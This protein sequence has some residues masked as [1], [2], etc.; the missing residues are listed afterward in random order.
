MRATQAEHRASLARDDAQA[1]ERIAVE[2]RVEAETKRGEAEAA[3]RS[4]RRTL[5]VSDIRLAQAAWGSGNLDELRRLLERQRPRPGEDD[6]RGF[7][8]HYLRRLASSVRVVGLP[9]QFQSAAIS[10][11]GARLVATRPVA[12]DGGREIELCLLDGSTG[13]EV[14]RVF[15]YPGNDSLGD[16]PSARFSPDGRRFVYYKGYIEATGRAVGLEGQGLG[17]GDRP[18]GL[19]NVRPLGDRRRRGV[20]RQRVPPGAGDRRP[21]PEGQRADR[22]RGRRRQDAPDDP[23]GGTP[24]HRVVDRL[25]PRRPSDRRPRPVGR[26]RLARD[27]RAAHLGR[28]RRRGDPPGRDRAGVEVPGLQPRRPSDR[29]LARARG[30]APGP[31]RRLGQGGARADR[32]IGWR[33]HLRVDRVQPRRLRASRPRPTPARCGSGT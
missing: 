14:R 27:R 18:R 16:Q 20:R 2:S 33:L 30:I 23:P 3:R 32:R 22:P 21:R 17:L 5:Y 9:A 12:I 15:P 25:Q 26:R 7:E 28:R 10:P 29:G 8:W 31:R 13:R 19:R 11:D 4:L 6:L 24:G 1:A